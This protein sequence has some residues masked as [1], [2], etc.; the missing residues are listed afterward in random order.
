MHEYRKITVVHDTP[1]GEVADEH[2]VL[3][4]HEDPNPP[5]DDLPVPGQLTIHAV[6]GGT[7]DVTYNVANVKSVEIG[8]AS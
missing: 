4:R 3:V 5:H 2:T 6:D 7:H 1:H 8:D